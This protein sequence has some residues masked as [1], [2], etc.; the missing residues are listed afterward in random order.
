MTGGP[1]LIMSGAVGNSIGF[2]TGGVTGYLPVFCPTCFFVTNE[3]TEA[4]NQAP[5][6][7]GSITKLQCVVNVAD[8]STVNTVTLRKN[9]ANGSN[10]FSIT[11]SGTGGF[12][13]STP[14]TDGIS[15]GDLIAIQLSPLTGASL[16][17]SVIAL[18]FTANTNTVTKLGVKIPNSTNAGTNTYFV[19]PSESFGGGTSEAPT[20]LTM[21]KAMTV[22]N[23]A[24]YNYLNNITGTFSSRKNTAPG[25]LSASMNLNT[26]EK[27]TTHSDNLSI[28]DLYDYTYT[29]DPGNANISA[30]F[31]STTGD[32]IFVCGSDAS[33]A[34]TTSETV[35]LGLT[36]MTGA[37]ST[38]E[39]DMKVTVNT[40][41]LFSQLCCNVTANLITSATTITLR[42]NSANPASGPSLSI[43][44][45]LTGV[46]TDTVNTYQAATSD[47]MNYKVLTGATGTAN[48]MQISFIAVWGN[49]TAGP[50]GG[51][52]SYQHFGTNSAIVGAQYYQ[53]FGSQMVVFGY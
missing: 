2:V 3:T 33:N 30:D 52:P 35:Y 29:N 40:A 4:V 19:I 22:N 17:L 46:F 12:S 11:K 16:G 5:F 44:N 53:S 20:K 47:L 37:G 51:G 31:T 23:L 43:G 25:N 39:P 42:V 14:H 15:N 48:S 49:A 26:L 41:F 50:A 34:F 10:T 18:T 8:T 36:G 38:N 24:V 28:S 27:D 6:V 9:G 13:D 32:V 45:S 21:R 7:A 1:S